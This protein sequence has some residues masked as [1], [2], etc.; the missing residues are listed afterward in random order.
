MKKKRSFISSLIALLIILGIL[1]GVLS[2]LEKLSPILILIGI[3]VLIL[4][5]FKRIDQ[6]YVNNST[7]QDR[8]V[9]P[10]ELQKEQIHRQVSILNDCQ[11]LVNE[12][13]S[14]KTV[15]SRYKRL[16]HTLDNLDQYTDIELKE[17]DLT[18]DQPICIIR[19][20]ITNKRNTIIKQAI[21]RNFTK[22]IS[23]LKTV[24]GK[25]N[26]L[27]RLYEELNALS[28]LTENDRVYLKDYYIQKKKELD[29]PNII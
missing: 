4:Y 29:I 23:S 2:I 13:A 26:A 11:S 9:I 27:D 28:D 1:S 3:V 16:L 14:V 6:K 7:R 22:R 8:P 25:L 12:S 10:T 19:A 21:A 24:K 5:I 17:A 20:E 18:F 15:L